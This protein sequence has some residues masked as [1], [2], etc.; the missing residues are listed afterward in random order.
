MTVGVEVGRI[1]EEVGEVGVA[2]RKRM[3]R[4]QALVLEENQGIT[5][6]H[7]SLE[8]VY[9]YDLINIL[10]QQDNYFIDLNIFDMSI[11]LFF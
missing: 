10:V 6:K 4:G 5:F 7:I 1:V 8:K 9:K 11:I 2:A 3:R